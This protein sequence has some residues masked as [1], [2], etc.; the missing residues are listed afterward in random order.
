MT[1]GNIQPPIPFRPASSVHTVDHTVDHTAV[2]S[3]AIRGRGSTS[4]LSTALLIN[5]NV[6]RM[7]TV[8]MM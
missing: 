2:T 4:P 8:R 3:G 5:C 1:R 7:C 6:D